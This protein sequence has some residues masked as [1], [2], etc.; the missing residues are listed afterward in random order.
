MKPGLLVKI[1]DPFAKSTGFATVTTRNNIGKSGV[2]VSGYEHR[3]ATCELKWH[4]VLIEGALR[5]FR[6]DYLVE[7][8]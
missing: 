6:E 7:V 2:V 5:Q 1:I 3:T 4:T 8:A